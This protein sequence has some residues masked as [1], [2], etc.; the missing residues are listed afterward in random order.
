MRKHVHRILRAQQDL[1]ST[2][3][4][5]S[6][7]AAL[8][9]LDNVLQST[10]ES[11]AIVDKMDLLETVATKNLRSYRHPII[12]E[13]VEVLLVAIV[14]ALAIRTFFLQPFKIPTG[15]MQPTLFGITHKNYIDDDSAEFPKGIKKW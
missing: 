13:N 8:I 10:R 15:S 1:L 11:K 12:R 3:S 5:E 6:V 2:E 14:V 9:E 4:V 7:N